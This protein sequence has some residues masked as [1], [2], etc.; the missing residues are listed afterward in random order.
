MRKVTI[1]PTKI[2]NKRMCRGRVDMQSCRIRR[3]MTSRRAKIVN[4]RTCRGPVDVQSGL[5]KDNLRRRVI[6]KVTSR[7]VKSSTRGCVEDV[8]ICKVV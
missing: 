2:V 3:K 1:R 7:P 6:R 5:E 4:K 8:S